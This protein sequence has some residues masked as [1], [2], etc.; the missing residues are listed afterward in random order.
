M[1]SNE[2]HA[3]LRTQ[4]DGAYETIRDCQARFL[5][6]RRLQA[7]SAAPVRTHR[8]QRLSA[9][10]EVA[11][12]RAGHPSPCDYLFR[13]AEGLACW[14]F[15]Q[16]TTPREGAARELVTRPTI[17]NPPTTWILLGSPEGATTKNDPIG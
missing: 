15:V 13:R 6:R 1:T 4:R 12:R 11:R 16:L 2:E 9:P 3:I 8:N 10:D 14:T 7:C 17:R 5:I